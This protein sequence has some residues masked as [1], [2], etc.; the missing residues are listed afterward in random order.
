MSSSSNYF[1][2]VNQSSV[3]SNDE[4]TES[5]PTKLTKYIRR[6]R[7][8]K[9]QVQ[10]LIARRYGSLH[11]FSQVVATYATIS[12][13]TGIHQDTVRTAILLYHQKGN[14]YVKFKRKGLG[15]GRRRIVPPDLEA[16]L[17]K[18]ETLNE[19]RFLSLRRRAELIRRQH[20]IAVGPAILGD[21][22]RR[23]GIRYLQAKKF[24]RVTDANQARYER[25]RIAFAQKI[26]G[27]QD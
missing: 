8:S 23:N 10:H 5:R 19:M 1:T 20:G 11:D 17:V 3:T 6:P 27:L 12:R 14:R 7:L 4:S 9:A 13:A 21:L 25:E 26:K 22:Y 16:E 2:P 15:G 18:W 24:T